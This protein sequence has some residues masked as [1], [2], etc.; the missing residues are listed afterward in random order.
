MGGKT[1]KLTSLAGAEGRKQTLGR[2]VQTYWATVA[3]GQVP[4]LGL[5]RSTEGSEGEDDRVRVGRVFREER[6]RQAT[7]EDTIALGQATDSKSWIKKENRQGHS[8]GPE[9]PAGQDQGP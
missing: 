4:G 2:T 3:M 6:L 1:R 8:S 5:L 7:S 9:S